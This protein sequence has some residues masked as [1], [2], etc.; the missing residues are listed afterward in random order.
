MGNPRCTAYICTT[1]TNWASYPRSRSH[2][3][4]ARSWSA[5]GKIPR[6]SL[7]NTHLSTITSF[8]LCRQSWTTV[9]ACPSGW[10][11][12]PRSGLKSSNRYPAAFLRN[13][14]AAGGHQQTGGGIVARSC[15]Y[16]VLGAHLLP[17]TGCGETS[18]GKPD[19]R[20]VEQPKSVLCC[21][22]EK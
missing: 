21:I 18:G 5:F 1:V 16:G 12:L 3:S 11:P 4:T 19:A 22:Y 13:L 7:Q 17:P 6:K 15:R 10:K 20:F 2:A 8:P 14:S 9:R